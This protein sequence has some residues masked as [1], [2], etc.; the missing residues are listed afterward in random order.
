LSLQAVRATGAQHSG[1]RNGS[2]DILDAIGLYRKSSNSVRQSWP[3]APIRQGIKG[4]REM[5]FMRS[6]GTSEKARSK[7]EV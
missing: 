1:R 4:G 3:T 7:A 2:N 6:K 5:A